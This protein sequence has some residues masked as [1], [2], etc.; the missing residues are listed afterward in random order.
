MFTMNILARICR[1]FVPVVV[2][3]RGG[4]FGTEKVQKA[5]APESLVNVPD[6]GCRM[7]R[8]VRGRVM[9]LMDVH[10]TSHPRRCCCST[11]GIWLDLRRRCDVRCPCRTSTGSETGTPIHRAH[12]LYKST[13]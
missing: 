1:V 9:M 12:L 10:R 7:I 11:F 6:F 2:V 3:E 13:V 8:L 5:T 4:I